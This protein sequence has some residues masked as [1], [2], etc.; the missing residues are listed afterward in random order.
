MTSIMM[1]V[2]LPPVDLDTIVSSYAPAAAVRRLL[3]ISERAESESF[4]L[5]ALR[6]PRIFS[7]RATTPARTPPSSSASAV[8]SAPSTARPRVGRGRTPRG[9]AAE[10]LDAELSRYKTNMIK[11]HRMGHADLGDFTATAATREAAFKCY[12]RTRDY[13]TTPRH[14]VQMCLNVVRVGVESEN[15]AHVGVASRR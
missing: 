4:V 6:P 11:V 5:D 1:D 7:R 15:Y 2:D 12:V 8:A 9:E 10:I 14:V 3:F 13:C